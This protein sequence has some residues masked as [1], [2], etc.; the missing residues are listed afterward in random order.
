M[1]FIAPRWPKSC[2]MPRVRLEHKQERRAQIIAAARTCFARAG[3]HRT[4]LQDIFAEAKLSAGCVY[5]YFQSK[6]EL[7]LA[8]AE[9]RHQDERQALTEA[10]SSEDAIEGLRSIAQRFAEDYLERDGRER[11]LIAIQTWAES[12]FNHDIRKS[13]I[14]GLEAPK[15]QITTLI[16]RGQALNTLSR[17]LDPEATACAMIAMFHGFILQKLWEPG[18]DT[19]AAFA[20]FQRFL[21]SL[22]EK[23]IPIAVPIAQHP[24]R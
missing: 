22:S 7:V 4:T 6:E 18:F 11:R 12:M 9:E 17:G 1:S 20:V 24:P 21:D 8:I 16:R 15:R 10:S 5:S 19:A 13:V 23:A 14:A 3:F 2:P